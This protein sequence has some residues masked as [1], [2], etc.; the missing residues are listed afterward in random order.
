[1]I[2]VT[3]IIL[4][5]CL[6]I[7]YNKIDKSFITFLIFEIY[8]YIKIMEKVNLHFKFNVGMYNEEIK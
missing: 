5:N 3:F 2:V 7:I 8:I 6:Y 4:S 1:M